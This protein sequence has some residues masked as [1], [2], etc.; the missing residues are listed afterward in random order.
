[1]RAGQTGAGGLRS[2]A[3]RSLSQTARASRPDL[4]ERPST[5]RTLIGCAELQM[6]EETDPSERLVILL[7]NLREEGLEVGALLRLCLVVRSSE[8]AVRAL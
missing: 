4:L 8:T 7:P 3:A 1:M 5:L 2:I 6:V